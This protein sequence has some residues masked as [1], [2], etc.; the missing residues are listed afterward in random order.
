M[1]SVVYHD[2]FN[3]DVYVSQ[4]EGKSW[5]LATDVPAGEANMV[6]EHPFDNRYAFIL[7]KGK[8]HYRTEDRGKTWRSF[9]MPIPPA[10]VQQPLSFHSDPAKFGYILYQGQQCDRLG[11]GSVCHDEVH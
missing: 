10:Y 8:T 2:A 5:D 3:G 9:T 1:Q 11:W 4:D 6:F 7:T